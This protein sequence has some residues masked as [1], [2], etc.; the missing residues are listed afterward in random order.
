MQEISVQKF[1]EKMRGVPVLDVRSPM[2]FA[3]GH[4]LGAVNMPLFDDTERAEV[5]TLYK[6]VGR[7]EAIKKGLEFAGSKMRAFIEFSESQ[8]ESNERLLY[9]WRGGMRSKSLGWL[10]DMYGF[11]VFLLQGGYKGFRHYLLETLEEPL[12]LLVLTGA[13][14]SGKTELLHALQNRGEQVLDLESLAHHKGSAF[15]GLGQAPQPT[16]E[17][18][19]NDLFFEL[20]SLDRKKRI[21]IE[22]EPIRIGEVTLPEPFWKQK[23]LAPRFLFTQDI[24]VRIER[25]VREYGHFEVE[26]LAGKID[27]IQ[28]KMGNDAVAKA[29]YHLLRGEMHKVAEVLLWYY[30]KAYSQSLQ[31]Y[32]SHIVARYSGSNEDFSSLALDIQKII[33]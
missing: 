11:D 22:D 2:E 1:I 9:C 20:L 12:P 31:K 33:L 27:K 7:Q 26:E 23:I 30:D 16:S 10:L 24:S 28:K 17:Q 3:Q 18:F 6:Q 13:T 21:W 4:I 19:Q 25:L 29:K 5:G 32:E 14:G 8:N 15:G